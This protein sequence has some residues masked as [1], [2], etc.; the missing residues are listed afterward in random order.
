MM[1]LLRFVSSWSTLQPLI[2]PLSK[3]H[4]QRFDSQIK[5]Q[6]TSNGHKQVSCELRTQQADSESGRTVLPE[7]GNGCTAPGPRPDGAPSLYVGGTG[8]K[9]AKCD[10]THSAHSF[11]VSFVWLRGSKEGKIT[12]CAAS[13]SCFSVDEGSFHPHPIPNPSNVLMCWRSAHLAAGNILHA[14]S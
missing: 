8:G 13:L 7:V 11:G 2:G 6:A 9:K 10:D 14:L 5:I 3:Q 4:T 12:L 1:L